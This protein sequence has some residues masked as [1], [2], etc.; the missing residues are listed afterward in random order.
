VDPA[1]Q[2]SADCLDV[3]NYPSCTTLTDGA[4]VIADDAPVTVIDISDQCDV[5]AVSISSDPSHNGIANVEPA[6]GHEPAIDDMAES[7]LEV[8]VDISGDE[9]SGSQVAEVEPVTVDTPAA[10]TIECAETAPV[11]CPDASDAATSAAATVET[12]LVTMAEA[13]TAETSSSVAAS[14]ASNDEPP[15]VCAFPASQTRD[16]PKAP[17]K[18]AEPVDRATLIRR[19]WVETGIR[20]WNPRLHGTGEAALNIQGRIE[21]LPPA[22]GEKMPRYDKLEFRMLGGQIVCEGVI[23]E[24]PVHAGQRSFTVLAERRHP[25]RAREASAERH[26]VLA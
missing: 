13:E 14:V 17:V 3:G 16:I 7:P 5:S 26:A 23:V 4:P 12:A 15:A 6:A 11:G 10:A 2:P 24:A 9:S 1:E 22:P 21:L 25:E 18:V 20:M 19:R 8:L